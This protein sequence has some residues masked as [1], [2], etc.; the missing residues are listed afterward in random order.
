MFGCRDSRPP[1][2]HSFVHAG[3]HA[4]DVFSSL[5]SGRNRREATISLARRGRAPDDRWPT[6]CLNSAFGYEEE[7]VRGAEF[8]ISNERRLVHCSAKAGGNFYCCC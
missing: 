6:L 5:R 1:R 2:A 8:T 3:V 4:I 7:Q